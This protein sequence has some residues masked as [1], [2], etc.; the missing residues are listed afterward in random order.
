MQRRQCRLDGV[1]YR[2]VHD[3]PATH[4]LRRQRAPRHSRAIQHAPTMRPLCGHGAPKMR[5][6]C[7]IAKGRTALSTVISREA[8]VRFF[9]THQRYVAGPSVD[10]E[11]RH[12]PHDSLTQRMHPYQPAHSLR[13]YACVVAWSSVARH[14]GG[15]AKGF[16]PYPSPRPSFPRIVGGRQRSGPPIH[17]H[18]LRA[19][20][21]VGTKRGAQRQ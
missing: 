20:K 19:G 3:A 1:G 13:V 2:A 12:F 14:G 7:H 6:A 8:T 18:T 21:P 5:L 9:F 17:P 10:K 11:C 15:P 16:H 4:L